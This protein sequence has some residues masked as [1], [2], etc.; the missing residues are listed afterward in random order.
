MTPP[1][2]DDL[3]PTA[4]ITDPVLRRRIDEARGEAGNAFLLAL[5]GWQRGLEVTF[6][7][8]FS[9]IPRFAHLARSGARGELLTLSDGQRRHAFYR[10]LGDATSREASAACESKPHT[11]RLWQAAGVAIPPGGVVSPGD[12]GAV[13]EKLLV[14]YPQARF[15]LKPVDGSLG[16]GV[17]RHLD[18]AAVRK[19]V[20]MAQQPHLL[21]VAIPGTEYRVHVV[22]ERVVAAVIRRPASVVGD[23][24]HTLERLIR[25]KEAARRRHSVYGASPEILNDHACEYL[26]Q[27]RV[28]LNAVPPRGDRVWVSDLPDYRVGADHVEGM[29][30]LSDAVQAQC[31]AAC[32]ALGMPNAGLDLIVSRDAAGR[33]K[34]VFL[35][36]NQNPYIRMLSC[37]LPGVYAGCGNRVAEAIIDHYFPGSCGRQRLTKASFDFV[38]ITR[39]LSSGGVANVSLRCIADDW[40]HRR[41]RLSAEESASSHL[42][43]VHQQAL[44]WNIH[45]QWLRLEDGGVLLDVAGPAHA[46]NSLAGSLGGRDMPRSA[47]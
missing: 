9:H 21:E 42:H 45:T 2:G 20:A 39:M 4:D 14:R 46:L 10:L 17:M 44:G 7:A 23:G 12:G 8:S 15:V 13:M 22:G 43:A 40:Q 6:H 3:P 29:D 47:Y 32:Q 41:F 35:E 34:A 28:D 33:P 5:A 19:A 18:A 31:V 37:P 16:Q 36:A 24:R 25:D 27:H 30:S 26:R 1:P 11:R 38:G